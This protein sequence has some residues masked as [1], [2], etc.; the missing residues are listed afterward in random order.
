M[1]RSLALLPKLETGQNMISLK[2]ELQNGYK[3]REFSD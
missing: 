2:T 1:F 3:K